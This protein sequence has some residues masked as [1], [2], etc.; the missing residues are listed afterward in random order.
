[1]T[2]VLEACLLA[3]LHGKN[4]GNQPRCRESMPS[5]EAI[6][7]NVPCGPGDLP[8]LALGQGM[9]DSQAVSWLSARVG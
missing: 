8:M 9:A 5:V 1:M 4:S 7:G 2:L 3:G 6:L